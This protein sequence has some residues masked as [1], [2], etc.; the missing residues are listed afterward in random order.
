MARK[1]ISLL[2]GIPYHI[3]NILGSVY[4]SWGGGG[5]SKL[6]HFRRCCDSYDLF[7]AA[8]KSH[9]S[10]WNKPH[11]PPEDTTSCNYM[12]HLCSGKYWGYKPEIE[13]S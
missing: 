11:C 13:A 8:A 10:D 6:F 3:W 7:L 4:R 9:S 1:A 5:L 12:A 2:K